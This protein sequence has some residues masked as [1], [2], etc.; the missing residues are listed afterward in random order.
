[1]EQVITNEVKINLKTV[2]YKLYY[3]KLGLLESNND[4]KAV[5]KHNYLGKYQ[6]SKRTLRSLYSK[7]LIKFNI[8]KMSE[9]QFL[10]QTYLQE[11]A[12]E[13]LTK[14]NFKVLINYDLLK[15]RFT[16]VDSV[17]ITNEG[18]LAAAHL[19]G[20][21]AVK[22]FLDSNGRINKKDANNTSVKDYLIHYQYIYN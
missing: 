17:F 12:I 11:E 8:D 7:K 21:A 5:N 15:Y 2:N 9:T 3:E 13:A 14:S 19:R 22:M 10:E 1:V 6:F 16:V 18:M 20:P 4:Y